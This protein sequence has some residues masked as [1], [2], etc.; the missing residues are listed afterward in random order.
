MSL[1][2]ILL[3]FLFTSHASA[4]SM[5]ETTQQRNKRISEKLSFAKNSYAMRAARS[6]ERTLKRDELASGKKLRSCRESALMHPMTQGGGVQTLYRGDGRAGRKAFCYTGYNDESFFGEEARD[7]SDVRDFVTNRNE[8]M[9][10]V[11]NDVAEGESPIELKYRGLNESNYSEGDYHV[12]FSKSDV[13]VNCDKDEYLL[14]MRKERKGFYGENVFDRDRFRAH[15]DYQ[16]GFGSKRGEYWL[17]LRRMNQVTAVDGRK[18]TLR[19]SVNAVWAG[20]RQTRY[21]YYRGVKV[22]R[23]PFHVITYESVEPKYYYFLDLTTLIPNNSS[24][25]TPYFDVDGFRSWDCAGHHKAGW[26][27]DPSNCQDRPLTSWSNMPFW[28]VG[29]KEVDW[30]EMHLRRDRS[31]ETELEKFVVEEQRRKIKHVYNNVGDLP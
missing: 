27:F 19:V 25:S 5:F 9:L 21:F 10:Y 2:Y 20:R 17:G 18:Y 16:T 23:A 15:A 29:L 28:Q 12:T 7:C 3:P 4:Q 24:F 1:I 14:V 26:W 11:A 30:S 31:E 6:I 22:G 8:Q 13:I